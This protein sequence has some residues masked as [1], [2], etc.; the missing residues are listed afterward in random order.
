MSRAYTKE[1]S[2]KI[3]LDH[4]RALVRYWDSLPDKPSKEKLEGLAF[5]IL[6]MI[7]GDSM[8]PSMDIVLRPNPA[9]QAFHKGHG[10]NWFKDCLILNDDCALHEFFHE[11]ATPRESGSL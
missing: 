7:D 1:E 6:T 5:S 4:I 2:R 10:E 11:R 3:V 8:L 9:D